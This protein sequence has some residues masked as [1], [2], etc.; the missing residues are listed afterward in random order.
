MADEADFEAAGKRILLGLHRAGQ[1]FAHGGGSIVDLFTGGQLGA[2]KSIDEFTAGV[3]LAYAELDAL[4][5]DSP[6]AR[7]IR[8]SRAIDRVR[9]QKV[10]EQ[11]DRDLRSMSEPGTPYGPPSEA[12][13]ASRDASA[14]RPAASEVRPVDERLAAAQET[15]RREREAA[16]AYAP[17]A[18]EQNPRSAQIRTSRNLPKP[19]PSPPSPPRPPSSGNV[20]LNEALQLFAKFSGGTRS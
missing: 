10:A 15:A 6:E 19:P 1:G 11:A 5:E 14:N 8:T 12:A 2:A 7:Y 3:G 17:P 16:R 18:L 20:D 13:D 4:P 9:T